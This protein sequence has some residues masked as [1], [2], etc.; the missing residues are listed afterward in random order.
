MSASLRDVTAQLNPNCR[1]L[2]PA[3][4]LH[5]PRF[6]Q[7]IEA[8][9]RIAD[10]PKSGMAQEVA[11]AIRELIST[12]DW[13]PE[14]CRVGSDECY[15]RHMLYADPEGRYTVMALVWRP[16]QASPVHGHTA[17][18]AMGVYS[19]YPSTAS[20]A[21]NDG[22]NPVQTGVHHCEPG[23]VVGLEPGSEEPHRVYNGSDSE[24][25]TLHTYG[26]DLVDEPCSIN[27]LFE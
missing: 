19:G 22:K 7:Y 17:W 1:A 11:A 20:Y 26:R 23:Q 21:C 24:V 27:I 10:R 4:L 14:D 3:P 25:I 5:E 18:C 15:K 2:T 16:G 13:L 9:N 8:V 12:P 6:M